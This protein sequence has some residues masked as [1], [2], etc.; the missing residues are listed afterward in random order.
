MDR[1]HRCPHTPLCAGRE[2][3]HAGCARIRA[4]CS[5]SKYS[6]ATR[7]TKRRGAEPRGL[8]VRVIA[9]HSTWIPHVDDNLMSTAVVG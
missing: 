4:S 1:N 2:L 3:G 7:T 6:I 8:L 5:T 9:L